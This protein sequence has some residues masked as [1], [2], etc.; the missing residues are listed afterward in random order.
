MNCLHLTGK[1]LREASLV[2]LKHVQSGGW[3]TAITYHRG[4]DHEPGQYS[5]VE[6]ESAVMG[7]I[8]PDCFIRDG[9]LIERPLPVIHTK[10]GKSC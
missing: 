5:K 4:G 1:A 7:T 10:S 8:R 6:R 3:V 9:L 2:R